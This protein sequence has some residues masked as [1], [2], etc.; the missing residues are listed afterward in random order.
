MKRIIQFFSIAL[1]FALPVVA[2]TITVKGSTSLAPATERWSTEF[3]KTKPSATIKVLAGGSATGFE[4]LIAGTAELGASS[5]KITAKEQQEITAKHGKAAEEFKVALDGVAIFVNAANGVERL[6]VQQL[7]DI[8]SGKITN[9]SQ[10]GGADKAITIYGR[11]TTSGTYSFVKE[12]VLKNKEFALSA[13]QLTSSVQILAGVGGD[14]GGIGYG[15]IEFGKGIKHVKISED[16][17]GAAVEPSLETIES[18][19]Y[20]LSRK[21]YFYSVGA[22]S[23]LAREFLK[24]VVSEHGQ[25]Q[26]TAIG[27][28]PLSK[29]ERATVAQSVE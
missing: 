25:S 3:S 28:F 15:S 27:L 23:G 22:P 2:Q 20:P 17:A 9:W 16:T 29:S 6:T 5:R 21:L 14:T 8:L 10:V 13:K 7:A 12:H 1:M 26:L 4:A 11:D 18:G 24:Y 19:K